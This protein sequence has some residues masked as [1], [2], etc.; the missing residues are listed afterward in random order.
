MVKETAFHPRPNPPPSR[1][2]AGVG[3]IDFRPGSDNVSLFISFV[4]A[5][6]FVWNLGLDPWCLSLSQISLPI[7]L[8]F[9][10]CY[11]FGIWCLIM[12]AYHFLLLKSRH[13]RTH[14]PFR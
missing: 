4:L 7:R 6:R 11:L 12:G 2:R 5:A 10:Y 3:G 8:E 9:G 13:G 14:R 1:G